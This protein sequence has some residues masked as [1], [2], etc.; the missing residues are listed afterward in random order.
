MLTNNIFF[1]FCLPVLWDHPF[2]SGVM[3]PHLLHHHMESDPLTSKDVW[4][5]MDFNV[6]LFYLA[7]NFYT[8]LKQRLFYEVHLSHLYSFMFRV[9][10]QYIFYLS[11]VCS[12][13]FVAFL[14]WLIIFYCS[15]FIHWYLLLSLKLHLWCPRV[16]GQASEF[17]LM[18]NK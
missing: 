6:Y 16:L 9:C 7:L 18:H 8:Y 15:S 13:V 10:F 17:M 2:K 14:N 1:I 4:D 3:I 5:M 12:F 11:V